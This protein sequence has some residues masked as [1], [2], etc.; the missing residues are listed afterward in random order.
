MDSILD[1]GGKFVEADSIKSY[2][3]VENLPT[4]GSNLNTAGTITI[5]IESQDEIIILEE[6]MFLSRVN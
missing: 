3:Y 1:V 4:S 6:A 5:H 2:E